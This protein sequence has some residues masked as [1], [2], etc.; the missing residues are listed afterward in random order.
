MR[1][2]VAGIADM[3]FSQ[4][5]ISGSALAQA[6]S[7]VGAAGVA[8]VLPIERIHFA[9]LLCIALVGSDKV[10]ISCGVVAVLWPRLRGDQ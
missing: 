8:G 10:F 7:N 4:S 3:C 6:S 1:S 9:L 2:G 5:D